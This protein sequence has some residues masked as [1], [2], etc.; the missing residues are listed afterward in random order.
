MVHAVITTLPTKGSLTAVNFTQ[1]SSEI[2]ISSTPTTIINQLLAV[3]Y[4]P[5]LNQYGADTIGFKVYH[6]KFLSAEA[7][8]H[9]VIQVRIVW[10]RV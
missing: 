4:E 3:H 7:F 6:D 1:P 2:S 9:I 5:F 10:V 8:V